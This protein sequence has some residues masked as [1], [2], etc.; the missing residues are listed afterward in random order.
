MCVCVCPRHVD[1]NFSPLSCPFLLRCA[2]SRGFVLAMVDGMDL[3][4]IMQLVG[5]NF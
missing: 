1:F 5:L 2:P 3:L 4:V